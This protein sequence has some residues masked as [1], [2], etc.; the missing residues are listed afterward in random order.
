MKELPI[1]CTLGDAELKERLLSWEDVVRRFVTSAEAIDGGF[2]LALDV[3]GSEL[4]QIH[5]LVVA[6]SD[7]CG[8]MSLAFDERAMRLVITATSRAGVDAIG[9]MLGL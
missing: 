2:S 4:Q 5:E 1:V 6:E 7:C 8:W 9:R 3:G